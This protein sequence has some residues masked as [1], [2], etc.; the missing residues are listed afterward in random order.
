M[1]PDVL[2]GNI[3]APDGAA[4]VLPCEIR[5]VAAVYNCA[6]GPV[7]PAPTVEFAGTVLI[8]GTDYTLRVTDLDGEELPGPLTELG[9][10][11]LVVSSRNLSLPKSFLLIPSFLS[12]STTFTSVEMAA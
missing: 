6:D 11:R 8:E 3:T 9:S 1:R 4:Y 7:A 10:Y 5:G 2:F 12:F